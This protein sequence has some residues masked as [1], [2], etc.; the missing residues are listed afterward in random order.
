MGHNVELDYALLG[1]WAR[2]N[3]IGTLTVIDGS[4]L[5]STQLTVGWW[6]CPAEPVGT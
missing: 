3:A 5:G 6:G 1:E 4:F 2:V